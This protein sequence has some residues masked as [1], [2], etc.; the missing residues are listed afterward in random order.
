[1]NGDKPATGVDLTGA[2]EKIIQSVSSPVPG[3][4][5]DDLRS[6]ARGAQDGGG[7]PHGSR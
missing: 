4:I 3:Q 2:A 1:M 7:D 6:G 5:S